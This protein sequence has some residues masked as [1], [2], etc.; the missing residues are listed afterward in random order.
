MSEG[1]AQVTEEKAEYLGQI[2]TEGFKCGG[3]EGVQGMLS[4]PLPRTHGE[5]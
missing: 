2:L 3:S 1:K 4:V 5:L